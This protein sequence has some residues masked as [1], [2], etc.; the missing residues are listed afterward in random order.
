MW[1]GAE[2]G[3]ER[4]PPLSSQLPETFEAWLSFY[5]FFKLQVCVAFVDCLI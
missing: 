3:L 1:H 2:V 4:W 5:S